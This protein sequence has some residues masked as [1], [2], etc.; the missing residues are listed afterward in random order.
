MNAGVTQGSVL[1]P[2]LFN[3]ALASITDFLPFDTV[4]EV[5]VLCR[6]MMS[7]CSRV[8]PPRVANKCS[9]VYSPSTRWT[10]SSAASDSGS[11]PQRPR[12]SSFTQAHGRGTR[13]LGSRFRRYRLGNRQGGGGGSAG[14]H[15]RT[16]CTKGVVVLSYDIPE[17]FRPAC[18]QI[19]T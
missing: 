2:F 18:V 10:T 12:H 13:C 15:V 5:R 11:P 7:H 19:I 16:Y 8:G 6:P 3:L 4:F 1:S 17:P 9:K 14:S